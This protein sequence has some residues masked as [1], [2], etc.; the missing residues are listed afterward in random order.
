[1]GDNVVITYETLFELY[2]REKSRGELQ[3]LD[4]DFFKNV[5]N[6]LTQKKA[7]SNNTSSDDNIF[8]EN[9]KMKAE[10]QLLNV[11]KILGLLYELRVRKIV[12]MAW[13]KSRDPGFFIDDSNL[14]LEEK[15][16][17]HNIIGVFD[18]NR[19]NILANILNYKLPQPEEIELRCET[20]K[21]RKEHK[22]D[23]VIK[24]ELDLEIIE[25]TPEFVGEDM[26]LLGPY[27]KGEITKLPRKVAEILLEKELARVIQD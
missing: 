10:K 5:V 12:D 22:I 18:S 11:K 26:N 7:I 2:R 20:I 4:K 9:E 24:D 3:E 19:K 8:A 1:M 23:E 13:I 16:I 14:L 27:E 15:S 17:Y 6:Y 25:N 21:E